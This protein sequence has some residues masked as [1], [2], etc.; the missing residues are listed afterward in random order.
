MKT[1][2]F[3]AM[4]MKHLINMWYLLNIAGVNQVWEYLKHE[5]FDIK[6]KRSFVGG[7]FAHKI[8]VGW[9]ILLRMWLGLVWVMEGVNKIGEGWFAWSSGSKSAWMF[10]EG[11]IQKGVEVV[12]AVSAA[13]GDDWA[14]PAT[15]A[16]VAVA[17][18]ATSTFGKV[19]DL[20]KP[21]FDPNGG[22]S[23]WFRTTF[24]D[25]M[26]AYLPYQGFQVM[27]VGME[28]AIGL[29]LFGGFFT[30]WAA[31]A[32]MAMCLIFTLSGMFAWDQLWFVFAGILMLGGAG[33][34]L[35][36]DYW[37][38]PFFKK[39]WNGTKFARKW[40]FYADDPTK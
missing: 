2:G 3:M 37:S 17:D 39:W 35:G 30:W 14:E 32:S 16:V 18:T 4:A 1:R 34:A 40:H 9:W 23:T 27:I 10:S 36:F 26:F 31:M 6:N 15:N 20:T 13:S 11:V 21:I 19:W 28:I 38:V 5:F 7:F 12:E 22:V 33:R 29:A 8:R 25:G 24:M